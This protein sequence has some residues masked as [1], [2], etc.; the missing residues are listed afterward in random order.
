MAFPKITEKATN[1]ELTAGL[2]SLIEQ[3]LTPI[4]RLIPNDATDAYCRVELEKLT[5]HVSGKIYRFEANL[6]AGGKKYYAEA[7]EEQVE[8][9]I[10]TVRDELKREL[11]RSHGKQQSL[12]KRGGQALKRMLRVE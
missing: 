1:I 4:G 3:K 12:L 2:S 6:F 11:E 9:A 10:D 7:T 5:E 8:K